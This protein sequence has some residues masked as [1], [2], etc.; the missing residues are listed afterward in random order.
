MC[1]PASTILSWEDDSEDVTESVL[2]GD[3]ATRS[4]LFVAYPRP[5]TRLS[6]DVSFWDDMM[7]GSND[8]LL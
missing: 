3:V 6:Y 8:V 4:K 7:E 1:L 5:L 2:A